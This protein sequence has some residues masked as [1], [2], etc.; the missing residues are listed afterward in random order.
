[1]QTVTLN[2]GR[3]AQLRSHMA[4]SVLIGLSAKQLHE[5]GNRVDAR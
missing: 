4:P 3:Q 2:N 5:N 1:M